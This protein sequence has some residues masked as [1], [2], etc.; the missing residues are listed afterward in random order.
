MSCFDQI[1]VRAKNLWPFTTLS[2]LNSRPLVYTLTLPCS[3]KNDQHTNSFIP[4]AEAA[5]KTSLYCFDECRV[6]AVCKCLNGPLPLRG[7]RL[8]RNAE[9]QTGKLNSYFKVFGLIRLGFEPECIVSV[10]DVLPT[11]LAN[12]V[13][14]NR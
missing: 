4:V 10:T 2:G 8:N 14:S 11:R 6:H 7:T 3:R 9:H 1:R 13:S 5:Q 12:W